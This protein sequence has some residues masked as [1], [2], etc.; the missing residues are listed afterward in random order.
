MHVISNNRKIDCTSVLA[1]MI[2]Q[3]LNPM[4]VRGAILI[5]ENNVDIFFDNN[6][7]LGYGVI[8]MH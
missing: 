8:H 1:S 3:S 7:F 4:M 6:I 2:T 5:H